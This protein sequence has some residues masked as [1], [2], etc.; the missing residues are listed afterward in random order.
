MFDR[1]ISVKLMSQRVRRVL[2]V[3][4][5][6]LSI[7]PAVWWIAGLIPNDEMSRSSAFTVPFTRAG[8]GPIIPNRIFPGAR[9]T[10]QPA[11]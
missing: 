3:A 10:R 4:F 2:I 5:G 6:V 9:P 7:A 1:Q 8:I 11:R